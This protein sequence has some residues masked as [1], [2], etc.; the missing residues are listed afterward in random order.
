M[1]DYTNLTGVIMAAGKGT[2]MQPFSTDIPKPM[3]PVCNIPL[4]EYHINIMKELGIDEII[5]VV[6]HLS[7]EIAQ[8]FGD[9]S[10]FGVKIKYVE[11]KKNLGIAHA[12]GM[13]EPHISSISRFLLFLGDIYFIPRNFRKMIDLAEQENN[14]AVLAVIDEKDPEAIKKNFAV[15]IDD[16]GRV[17]RVIEKPRYVKEC[18]KGCG[19][20]LFD[21]HI[22]D[23]IRRTPRSAMRDEY[24][25]TDAIQ[26]LIGDGFPVAIAEVIE[27]DINL[28]FA[29]DL[30]K[31]NLEHLKY[32]NQNSVI[33]ENV[34]TNGA[35]INS[36]VIGNNVVIS[37]PISIENSLILSDS[38]VNT[39]IDLKN[40][41]IAPDG[42]IDCRYF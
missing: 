14:S 23:A 10:A 31:C 32:T 28:T 36:S 26:I 19:I 13:L 16:K 21:P 40:I 34:K 4:L 42:I 33:G 11:Q 6:G 22:F 41:V 1:T 7:F 18:L 8:W 35:S 5:L 17:K 3:L 38:F 24:E 20:Y 39:K 29:R 30:L 9:G 27:S 15:I 37:H 12:V 2:R 25:L